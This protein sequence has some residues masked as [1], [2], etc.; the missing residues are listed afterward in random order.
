MMLERRWGALVGRVI[1]AV[2]ALCVSAGML[3]LL[4]SG[5]GPVPALGR[6][7]DPGHGAWTSATGGLPAHSRTLSLP[8]LSHPVS[9]AFTSHGVPSI[10]AAGES[11]AFLALGYLH[12]SFR[13]RPGSRAP[14]GW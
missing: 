1:H 14:R 9:V 10:R 3:V 4:A 6:A 7:L 2:I 5:Y 8:G 12:A 13:R 11:D